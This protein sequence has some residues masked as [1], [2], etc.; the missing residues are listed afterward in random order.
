MVFFFLVQWKPGGETRALRLHAHKD[1]N[2]LL[3]NGLLSSFPL[4]P[5]TVTVWRGLPTSQDF[6]SQVWSF[7][8]QQCDTDALA[9]NIAVPHQF[10]SF[11]LAKR[12]CRSSVHDISVELHAG[13]WAWHVGVA[14]ITRLAFH[15]SKKGQKG[16]RHDTQCRRHVVQTLCYWLFSSFR[17]KIP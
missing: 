6:C 9:C 2:R 12:L 4:I 10:R 11:P 8:L 16:Q 15:C 14:G 7:S 5:W 17:Y 1:C 3:G 13:V